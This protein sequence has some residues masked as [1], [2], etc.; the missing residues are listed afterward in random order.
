M[1]AHTERSKRPKICAFC[2]I[3]YEYSVVFG[4]YVGGCAINEYSQ[5][6]RAFRN[7]RQL[8]KNKKHKQLG[9]PPP[10]FTNA[11]FPS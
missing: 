9:P 3:G 1:P 6:S 10:E 8:T 2:S 11:Y 4:L 7:F 5:L